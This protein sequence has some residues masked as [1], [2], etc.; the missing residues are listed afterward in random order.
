MP[1]TSR[2]PSSLAY[3]A[4]SRFQSISKWSAND[5]SADRFASRRVANA[6]ARSARCKNHNGYRPCNDNVFAKKSCKIKIYALQL[7]CL[8]PFAKLEDARSASYAMIKA[9]KG[10][11]F[12]KR[13]DAADLRWSQFT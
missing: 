5:R 2:R 4:T 12:E 10:V 7:N 8:K 9:P 1:L 6:L 11:I 3:H 13:N